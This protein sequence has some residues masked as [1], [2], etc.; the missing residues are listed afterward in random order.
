M[1]K[2]EVIIRPGKLEEVKDAVDKLGLKGMT[3]SE[4]VGRGQQKP[5]KEIY[6]GIEYSID[7]LPRLKV[8]F[9][10]TEQWVNEAVKVISAVACTGLPG[11]GLIFVSN[12]ENAIR[13]RTG[14]YGQ[15]ALI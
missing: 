14:E 15:A 4:V 3:I 11:D 9:I 2:V 10:M 8:E 12:V 6:R 5:R 7:L 13:I 1:K